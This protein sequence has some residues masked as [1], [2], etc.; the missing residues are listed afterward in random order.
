MHDGIA[1]IINSAPGVGKSTLLRNLH[2]RL[3]DGFAIIDGDDVGRI[4]P[5]QNNINWLNVIQDN[6]ADCCLNFKRYGNKNCIISFVFPGEER[7]NRI[8]QLLN[9][10]GFEIVHILLE[11]NEHEIERRITIRDTSRLIN[12]ENAKRLSREMSALSVDFKVDT[13]RIGADQVTDI[14]LAYILDN[15]SML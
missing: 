8:T 9:A 6:I 7:L 2:L 14:I 10:R 13:T 11:C 3:P 4:I 5:Y 12:I 15:Q 1:Y